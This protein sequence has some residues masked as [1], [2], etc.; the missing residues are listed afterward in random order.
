VA[1]I[2]D[3]AQKLPEKVL[4]EIG[5]LSSTNPEISRRLQFVFV[6]QSEFEERVD[7][8]GLT[9]FRE[10]LE[11]RHQIKT[12]TEEESKEYIDHRLK[13][14][15][16]NTSKVFHPEAIALICSYA[17][18]IPRTIN[19]VCDNA[20]LRGYGSSKAKIDVDTLR[21]AIG[22][23]EGPR[24]QKFSL[25]SITQA[26]KGAW[27]ST[28]RVIPLSKKASLA[29]LL[30]LCLGGLVLVTYEYLQRTPDKTWGGKIS[31]SPI[32]DANP[33]LPSS[34][35]EEKGTDVMDTDAIPPA[36]PELPSPS[37]P[38]HSS[39]SSPASPSP[40]PASEGAKREETV[41]V[42]D[43]QSLSSLAEK[44]YHASN[45]SLVALILDFNPEITNANY[46][47][48]DQKVRLPI[49]TE[50]LLIKGVDHAY[51]IQVGT[52]STADAA[53]IYRDEP[54]IKG[55]EIEVLSR[56]VSPSDTWHSVLIG[57]FDRKEEALKMIDLLRE[58]GLLPFFEGAPKSK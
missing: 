30:L 31:R 13:L 10:R 20:L 28:T 23:L 15:E 44:F 5:S 17:R 19:I 29:V 8:P 46:I 3:E 52:F 38:P 11:I 40:P 39:P 58:K 18:G 22:H 26:L 35:G 16:S 45:T 6:G 53:R 57:R 1:V 41:L 36:K 32:D 12:L 37:S 49:L 34:S 21:E 51:K 27:S 43:G 42:K 2:L 9:Q 7:S 25:S 24:S 50:D 47:T 48:V 4:K 14:V 54:A 56:R 33:S 55:K